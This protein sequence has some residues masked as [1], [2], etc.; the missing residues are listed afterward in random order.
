MQEAHEKGTPVM[1]TLFY[2]FPK[3]PK[4][5]ETEEEYMY[6]SRYLIAPVMN[7]REYEKTVYL[8]Q[9]A[10]WKDFYTEEL[11]AGGQSIRTACPLNRIPVFEKI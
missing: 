11:F 6:G 2:E 10:N 5:W 8:P 1:R 7:A 4:C 9:G 3:D